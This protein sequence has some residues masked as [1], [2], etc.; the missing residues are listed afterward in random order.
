[1]KPRLR[2]LLIPAL[3]TAGLLQVGF[4]V[5]V[6]THSALLEHLMR[7]DADRAG[8]WVK[9]SATVRKAARA[10][11]G[12]G[13][14]EVPRLGLEAAVVEGVD[15]RSLLGGVGHVPG[16]AFPGERD[17][18]ALAGHRDT[19]FHPL[20]K[21]V[22]GDTIRVATADGT[23]LYA[24]DKTFIVTPDRADLMKPTG[25]PMLTLITCYP[26]GWIGT[27]PERFVVRAHGVIPRVTHAVARTGSPAPRRR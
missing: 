3:L 20:R 11:R 26:F 19:H 4:V 5:L 14:L 16:T 18:V 6:A 10:G 8:N 24:V 13:H 1:M 7:P 12:I 21:I 23:F 25:R 9:T 2:N 27:A 17:N 15:D 22:R